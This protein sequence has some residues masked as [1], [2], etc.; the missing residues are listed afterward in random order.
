MAVDDFTTVIRIQRNNPRAYFRRAFSLKS[1]GMFNEAAIDFKKA[2]DLD[3][4]NGKF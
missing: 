4:T 3:P 2:R 1:L